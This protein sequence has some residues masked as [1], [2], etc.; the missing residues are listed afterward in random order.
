MS[1]A[2]ITT[3]TNDSTAENTV[4]ALARV[5]LQAI[6]LTTENASAEKLEAMSGYV[7]LAEQVSPAIG[8]ALILHAT[9]GKPIIG[10]GQ[11]AKC[12]VK[13]GMVPGLENNKPAITWQSAR[14]S[15]YMRLSNDYQRNAFTKH[16]S[17]Q[18]ILTLSMQPPALGFAMSSALLA[19]MDYQGLNLLFYCDQ[20]GD[21]QAQGGI[22]A[23]CNKT[24]NILAILPEAPDEI[25]SSMRDY[26]AMGQF[27]QVLPLNYYPR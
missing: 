13:N 5:G 15:M 20:A 3:S 17:A 14:A 9:T 2:I 22:A 6:L 8:Q 18:T 16:L 7:L 12:L 27:T 23:V 4:L 25:F 24:G 1:I 10:I 26:I 11:G 21:I 19:E